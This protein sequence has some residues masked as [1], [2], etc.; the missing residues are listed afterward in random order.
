VELTSR[1]V[2]GG[3]FGGGA[4][5]TNHSAKGSS[6]LSFSSERVLSREGVGVSIRV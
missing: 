6:R 1:F 4:R 5:G 3:E 2:M